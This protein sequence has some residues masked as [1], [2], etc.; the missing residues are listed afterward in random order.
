MTS[1]YNSTQK[2]NIDI[3]EIYVPENKTEVINYDIQQFLNPE[4][5]QQKRTTAKL[6]VYIRKSN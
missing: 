3:K 5:Y 4:Y 2:A 1:Y 6:N